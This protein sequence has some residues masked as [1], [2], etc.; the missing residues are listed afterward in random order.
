MA[1]GFKTRTELIER[2]LSVLGLP[3]AGQ[4]PSNEDVDTVDDY[5]DSM[6]ER[7]TR[8]EILEDIDADL[9]PEAFF[10]PLAIILANI[11]ASDFTI[12]GQQAVDV[13]A[14]ALQAE[15]DIRLMQRSR[16]TYQPQEVEWF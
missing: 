14:R 5:I 16:P 13:A 15:A 1:L 11:V 12:V 4:S 3:G 8:L 7:L 9:I 6:F 10:T 2:A